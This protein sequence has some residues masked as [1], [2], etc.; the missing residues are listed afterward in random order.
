M[1]LPP[2]EG[3]L[4]YKLYAALLGYVN[5]KLDV[6]P[7]QFSESAEYTSLPPQ[8]RGKVRDALYEHRELIDQFVAEN[9][10]GLSPEELEVVRSW[11]N[12]LVGRF[13][14][15]RYLKKYTIF[16]SASGEAYKAY[17]VLGLADP[18]EE[19]VGPYLPVL[20]NAVLLPFKGQI[21]YDGLI[22][23]YRVSFGGGA[24]R[25]LNED[26]NRAKETFGIIMSLGDQSVPLP[27]KPKKA[28]KR[29]EKLVLLVG[30]QSASGSGEAKATAEQL[31]KMT[32][33]FCKKFLNEEYAE[34][35]RRL[36]ETL[37]RK[38]P[39][40][41]LQGRLETWASG[42]VRTIGWV[43][44][45]HDPSQSPHLKLS[46]IDQAF[47]VAESTGAAKLKAI[48]TMLRIGQLD[49]KWTLPSRMDDNPLAWLLEVNGFMMDIRHAPRE[50]QVLAYEKGMIPYIPA[51]RAEAGNESSQE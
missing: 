28:K 6:L 20:A 32:D 26:Y 45:L 9:P 25:N 2:D 51:D 10:A 44:F 19:V 21:I 33:A 16:L 37:A 39:S 18:M 24:R 15:F 31:V 29:P 35:S 3:K 48:R 11:K 40:P 17:G 1:N 13:Y 8:T 41:L 22:A 50:V 43:N 49:P 23:P 47:G 4:F 36:V 30:R 5:R 46:S 7:K 27:A 42:I 12:A 34:L 38:R 14:I